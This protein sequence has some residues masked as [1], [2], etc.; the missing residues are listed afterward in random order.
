MGVLEAS[1][2]NAQQGNTNANDRGT[3]LRNRCFK[4]SIYL[5]LKS[6]IAATS[7]RIAALSLTANML[8]INE[9]DRIFQEQKTV[10][11]NM[12]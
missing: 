8:R 6:I 11:E 3:F 12:Y 7:L 10:R 4:P 2:G 9:Y 5:S 1:P